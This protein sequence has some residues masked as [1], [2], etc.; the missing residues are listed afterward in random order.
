M[1]LFGN[2]QGLEIMLIMIEVCGYLIHD[3]CCKNGRHF[4]FFE[5][6]IIHLISNITNI[7][8]YHI[9]VACFWLIYCIFIQVLAN[10]LK[11]CQTNSRGF[12]FL[13]H[14]VVY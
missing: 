14:C 13:R 11:L 7:I 6:F 1:L 10:T 2:H 8:I 9:L 3:F 12:F 5:S 4:E